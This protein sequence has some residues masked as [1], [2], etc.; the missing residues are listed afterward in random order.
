MIFTLQN[1]IPTPALNSKRIVKRLAINKILTLFNGDRVRV[2]LDHYYVLQQYSLSTGLHAEW[3]DVH[4]AINYSDFFSTT[5]NPL[6]CDTTAF[7][8]G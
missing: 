3:K 7:T 8:K 2:V 1:H 5:K 6:D 4:Y